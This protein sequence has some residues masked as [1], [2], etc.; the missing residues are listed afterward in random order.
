MDFRDA[1]LYRDITDLARATRTWVRHAAATWTEVG[2]LF[3][4]A[5]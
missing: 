2:L 3:V 4:L 5:W 1:D